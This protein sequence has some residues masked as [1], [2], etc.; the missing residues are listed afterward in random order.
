MGDVTERHEGSDDDAR[1][2][3]VVIAN[4]VLRV[5]QSG[6]AQWRALMGVMALACSA[7]VAPLST[8]TPSAAGTAPDV[9]FQAPDFSLT[10]LDGRSVSLSDWRGQVVLLNFWATWCVPCRAEMPQIQA[11]YQ[12]YRDRNFVVLSIN[13]K[14]DEQ[15]VAQFAEAFHL[16]MPVLLDHDGSTARRYRVRGLPTSFLVD[17]E[18]VIREVRVGEINHAYIET[19]LAALGVLA[20]S[21][22]TTPTPATLT[23]PRAS[24]DKSTGMTTPTPAA[25]TTVSGPE[26][27]NLDE[28]FPP[29]EGQDLVLKTCLTCHEVFTFGVARKTRVAWLNNKASHIKEFTRLSDEARPTD[30]EVETIYEYLV[31]DF[32]LD[33]PLSKQLPPSYV[34]GV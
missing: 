16:T 9:G 10:T 25:P 11:A 29:G 31:A 21:H 1:G 14:E 34:C 20:V 8:Y 22:L 2:V 15:E 32:N 27:V 3:V 23:P 13:V 30:A 19:Q 18:G 24:T 28:I 12:A 17:P 4:G 33:R 5:V 26:R 7:C 6:R